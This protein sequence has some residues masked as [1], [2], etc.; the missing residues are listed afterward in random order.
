MAEKKRWWRATKNRAKDYAEEYQ[1]KI[2]I[3][4]KKEGQELSEREQGRRQGYF[5]CLSDQAGHFKF[6]KAKAAGATEEEAIEYSRI[7]GKGGEDIIEKAKK[8][9][10]SA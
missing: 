2:H 1:K 10:K 9:K 8:R 6:N 5:E 4:G 7:I 3:R